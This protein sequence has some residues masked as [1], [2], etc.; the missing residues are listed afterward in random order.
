MFY[1]HYTTNEIMVAGTPKVAFYLSVLE[2]FVKA[3]LGV[4]KP[5]TLFLKIIW[6]FP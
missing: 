3:V 2:D 5:D 4:R 1:K 6:C